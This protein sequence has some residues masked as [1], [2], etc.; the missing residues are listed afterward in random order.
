MFAI[1]IY[2]PD[3][4]HLSLKFVY[5]ILL[6]LILSDYFL[7]IPIIVL[8]QTQS[9]SVNNYYTIKIPCKKYVKAY[10]EN[11]AGI[12][13]NLKHLPEILG[14]FKNMLE[15]TSNPRE[16]ICLKVFTETVIIIIPPD[17]FYRYGYEM[18]KESIKNL[19]L[20]VEEK[21]KFLMRQYVSLNNSLGLKIAPAI[22]EIQN[23]FGFPEPV[24]SFESIKKEFDRHG[25][26]SKLESIIKLKEEMSETLLSNLA[27]E[28]ILSQYYKNEH[29]KELCH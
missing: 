20:I 1:K 9:F 6:P 17:W 16:P 14:E 19:N 29:N 3:S 5:L 28:G 13:V 24:W 7:I 11:N 12:P 8:N 22:R 18:S 10:L 2:N 23:K 25:Q 21:V 26:K 15:K 4:N 27:E